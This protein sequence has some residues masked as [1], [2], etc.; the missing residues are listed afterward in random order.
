MTENFANYTKIGYSY[1]NILVM[2]AN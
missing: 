2:I 1:K